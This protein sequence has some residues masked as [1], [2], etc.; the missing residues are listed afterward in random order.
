MSGWQCSKEGSIFSVKVRGVSVGLTYAESDGFKNAWAWVTKKDGTKN[1]KVLLE[2][3]SEFRKGYLGWAYREII[4]QNRE[5]EYT[6]HV[7]VTDE[8]CPFRG[9][10][11]DK[12]SFA[13]ITGIILGGESPVQ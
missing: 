6:L 9:G 4:N 3:Y 13:N 8:K 5:E 1:P 7:Q 2:C 10:D 12:N 11:E